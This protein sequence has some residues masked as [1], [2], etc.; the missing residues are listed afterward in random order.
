MSSRGVWFSLAGIFLLASLIAYVARPRP[1][2]QVSLAPPQFNP[3]PEQNNPPSSTGLPVK[4]PKKPKLPQS[5]LPTPPAS[6]TRPNDNPYLPTGFTGTWITTDKTEPRFTRLDVYTSLG[7]VIVHAW[8]S[9]DL[10]R[11]FNVLGGMGS[12]CND[13]EC[14]W[15]QVDARVIPPPADRQ[16]FK[17]LNYKL[18]YK[19]NNWSVKYGF[20]V[21]TLAGTVISQ[22]FEHPDLLLLS[23]R[24]SIDNT[25]GHHEELSWSSH[26]VR[27]ARWPG[28]A[29][30][31][32]KS[33]E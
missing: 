23:V 11:Y 14:D 22:E 24:C 3:Q 13:Q 4:K 15:G 12:Q 18:Q 30:P 19:V 1:V 25:N 26:F 27:Y 5:L 33:R 7:E 10:P 17:A 28:V 21:V 29:V 31:P 32:G 6:T 2:Q 9:L 20:G 8:S 16:A